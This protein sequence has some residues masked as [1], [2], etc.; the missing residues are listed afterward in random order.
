[1]SPAS[2]PVLEFCIFFAGLHET[3]LVCSKPLVLAYVLV[4][5]AGSITVAFFPLNPSICFL[6]TSPRFPVSLVAL[7]FLFPHPVFPL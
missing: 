6:S 7:S 4:S 1:M 3:S 5:L 2:K